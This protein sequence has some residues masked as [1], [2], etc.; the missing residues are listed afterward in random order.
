MDKKEGFTK[1]RESRI[2]LTPLFEG[3]KEGL[4]EKNTTLNY[5]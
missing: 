5:L 2:H 1:R 3:T 4:A